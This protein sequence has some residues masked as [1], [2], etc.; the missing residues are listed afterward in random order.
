MARANSNAQPKMVKHIVKEKDLELNPKLV[1]KGVKVGD[2]IEI[3]E[4]ETPKEEK[5]K[6][7]EVEITGNDGKKYIKTY[8]KDGSSL[9]VKPIEE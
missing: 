1:S 6:T 7:T 5:G 4:V 8:S 2:E 3:P 9:G